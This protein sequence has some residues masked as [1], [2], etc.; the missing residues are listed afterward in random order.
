MFSWLKPNPIRRLQRRY[1]A[2]LAEARVERDRGD[3]VLAAILYD[4]ADE[5][6]QRLHALRQELGLVAA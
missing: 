5:L 4:E 6:A 1:L 3:A 2:K